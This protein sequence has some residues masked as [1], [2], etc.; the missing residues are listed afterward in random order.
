MLTEPL[1]STIPEVLF[2]SVPKKLLMIFT[3]FKIYDKT[4]LKIEK[5]WFLIDH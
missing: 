1:S 3:T 4:C 5:T 2:K